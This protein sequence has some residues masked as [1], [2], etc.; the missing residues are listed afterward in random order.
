MTAPMFTNACT[1]NQ[2][3][4]PVASSSPKRSGACRA[5]RMPTIPR[6]TNSATTATAPIRPS[7]SPITAKMKSEWA[8]GRNPHLAVPAPRPLPKRP[9][10]AS[11]TADWMFW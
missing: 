1:Q 6:T 3:V 7:S 2:A 10:L 11:P 4:T 5:I 8:Y 9:P